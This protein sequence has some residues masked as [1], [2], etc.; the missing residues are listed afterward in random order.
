MI[1]EKEWLLEHYK[2]SDVRVID[3]RFQL[4]NPKLGR[5]L[6]D[7][8]HIP[9]SL[10]F[11]LE[12][13]LSSSVLEHGGRHPLP[14]LSVFKEKLELAGITNTSII[15]AYDTGEMS[16]ASR[17]LWMLKYIGHEKAYVLN[18]GFN[19]WQKEGYPLDTKVPAFT[20]SEYTLHIQPNI[21]ASYEEVKAVSE[22]N[23]SKTVL[24]DSREYKRY[25]GFEEPIDKKPGHIPGAINR[26][27]T[28][29]IKNGHFLGKEQQLSRFQELN[30]EK[31]IIV[32]CGS[33]VTAT[34][35][36]VAL[37]QAGFS[38]VKVYI[39]SYSDWVSYPNNPVDK[40]IE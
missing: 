25:A 17:L 27:W 38:N 13:D 12:E 23:D 36:Y 5:Q 34:P 35:N 4:Q 22:S 30:R 15:V 1:V 8:N 40:V 29:G 26:P 39:G 24:I 18:G 37:K 2:E 21:L 6:Y 20:K 33:G 9:N 19:G 10:Y 32:Y 31:E 28:E 7:E 3:C 14:N 16:F 11:H